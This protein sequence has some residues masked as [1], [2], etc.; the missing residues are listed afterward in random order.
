MYIAKIGY[1][2]EQIYLDIEDNLRDVH[3]YQNKVKSRAT[4][5]W[6][7]YR[8]LLHYKIVMTFNFFN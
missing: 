1:T 7:M 5:K 3:I 8:Y 4:L 6:S 2:S